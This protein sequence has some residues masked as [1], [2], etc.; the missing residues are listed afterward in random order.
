MN[1]K[2]YGV[3][4]LPLSGAD[5]GGYA[6]VVPELSGCRSDGDTPQ[7]ALENADDAIRCWLEAVDEMGRHAPQPRRSAA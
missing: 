5:G 7:E 2:G 4:I 1:V 6:A 3:D